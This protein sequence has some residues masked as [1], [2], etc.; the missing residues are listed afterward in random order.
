MSD[1]TK[2]G[3]FLRATSLDELPQLMN[4]LKEI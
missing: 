4:I 1:S 3:K 2:S